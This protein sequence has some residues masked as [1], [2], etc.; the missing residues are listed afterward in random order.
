MDR[1]PTAADLD[2][3]EDLVFIPAG[4]AF[5][6]EPVV[7]ARDAAQAS[8]RVVIGCL[9]WNADVAPLCANLR[10]FH[11]TEERAA[12]LYSALLRVRSTPNTPAVLLAD[13]FIP[14]GPHPE[15]D[16]LGACIKAMCG[17]YIEDIPSH[18]ERV[19]DGWKAKEFRRR[20]AGIENDDLQA[21]VALTVEMGVAK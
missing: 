11:F 21:L 8:G 17:V 14:R 4:V 12:S 5:P 10:P 19:I 1:K 6:R 18:I 13:D 16:L 15:R 2:D 7:P 9:Y 3:F 20:V